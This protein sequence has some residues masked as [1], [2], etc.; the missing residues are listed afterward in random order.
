MAWVG[1][2]GIG[3]YIIAVDANAIT[4]RLHR[5]GKAG[6]LSFSVYKSPPGRVGSIVLPAAPCISTGSTQILIG[7]QN[8]FVLNHTLFNEIRLEGLH[9]PADFTELGRRKF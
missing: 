6:T 7:C 8:F 4:E 2:A 1:G 5:P 3:V 9:H